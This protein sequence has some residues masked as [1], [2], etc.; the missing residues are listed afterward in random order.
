MDAIYHSQGSFC[1]KSYSPSLHEILL[2]IKIENFIKTWPLK[3]K[4]F[5]R[6]C[7]IWELSITLFFTITTLLAFHVRCVEKIILIWK[8]L[9]CFFCLKKIFWKIVQNIFKIIILF[10]L[11]SKK[12]NLLN[13]FL[14][15]NKTHILQF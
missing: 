10:I 1:F 5:K 6:M 2:V 15:G 7:E 14:Q 9:Y 13:V 3:S 4:C 12:L 8:E 11:Y